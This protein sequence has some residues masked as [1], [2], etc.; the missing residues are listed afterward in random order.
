MREQFSGRPWITSA[1]FAELIRRISKPSG[2]LQ[3]AIKPSPSSLYRVTTAAKDLKRRKAAEL[4]EV[5]VRSRPKDPE[6]RRFL[7]RS[8][9]LAGAFLSGTDQNS[10][11]HHFEK[12]ID[13]L[14]VAHRDFPSDAPIQQRLAIAISNISALYLNMGDPGRSELS[15]GRSLDILRRLHDANPS[16]NNIQKDLARVIRNRAQARLLF[17]SLSAASDDFEEAL[18]VVESLVKQNPQ[19]S[20]FRYIL[21]EVYTYLGQIRRNRVGPR[22][23][24]APQPG[25]HLA[26]RAPR[27]ASNYGPEHLDSDREPLHPRWPRE[28]V[29]PDR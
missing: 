29:R 5:V 6:A 1:V 10:S 21:G 17:G 18:R 14:T 25:D 4:W 8:Y 12:A 15:V 23:Q 19:V 7:G 20:D 26:E 9:D 28:G 11:E 3:G 22:R 2:G 27:P 16:S 13:V 24:R